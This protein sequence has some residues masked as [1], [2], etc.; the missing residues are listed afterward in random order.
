MHEGRIYDALK[1]IHAAYLLRELKLQT[2]ELGLQRILPAAPFHC[3]LCFLLHEL[4]FQQICIL[5][6]KYL[7]AIQGHNFDL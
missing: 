5:H 4:D 7:S 6:L 3:L 1:G 2:K